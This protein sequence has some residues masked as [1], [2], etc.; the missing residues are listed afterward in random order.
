MTA[1]VKTG[2]YVS[3][4]YFSHLKYKAKKRNIPFSLTIEDLD[5]L[6]VTQNHKCVYTGQP[7]DAKTRRKYSASLDRI[8]S[9]KPYTTSNV[10]WVTKEVNFMKHQL[11]EEAFLDIVE[12]I[13]R[14]KF[15]YSDVEPD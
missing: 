1:P 2:E 3:G 12:Q 9:S 6:M 14:R 7:L 8:D 15:A 13:Y 4:D 11:S 5:Q 10:Q